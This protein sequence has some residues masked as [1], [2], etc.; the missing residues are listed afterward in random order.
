V[1]KEI[2]KLPADSPYNN[3]NEAEKYFSKS[4][5]NEVLFHIFDALI[6]INSTNKFSRYGKKNHRNIAR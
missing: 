2:R 4:L 5:G 1:D 6:R 3:D